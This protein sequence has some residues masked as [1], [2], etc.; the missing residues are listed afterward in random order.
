MVGI[1][2]NKK[3]KVFPFLFGI[4]KKYYYLCIYNL[5]THTD[6]EIYLN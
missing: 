5:K 3:G 2:N 6:A 4:L 1:T